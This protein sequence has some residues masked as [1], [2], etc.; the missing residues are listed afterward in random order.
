MIIGAFQ[1][2]YQATL[3]CLNCGDL[4]LV[5]IPKGISMRTYCNEPDTPRCYRCGCKTLTPARAG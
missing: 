3:K 2:T 1:G 5:E 4:Y